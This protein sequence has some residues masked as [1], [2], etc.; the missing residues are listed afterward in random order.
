MNPFLT[1]L[2]PTAP[3]VGFIDTPY[4]VPLAGI[5]LAI[6]AVAFGSAEKMQKRRLRHELMRLAIERGQ[7]LP[8]ELLE[9]TPPRRSRDDRRGGLV[10]IAVGIGVFL[11]FRAI[12]VLPGLQWI[13]VVPVLIGC[14]LLLNWTLDRREGDRR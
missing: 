4:I 8:P 12:A 9:E 14:A 5:C 7:P 11:F 3:L 2:P 1:L 13:G 6:V 10:S